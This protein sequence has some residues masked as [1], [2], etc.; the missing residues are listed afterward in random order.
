MK[1]L[2][3]FFNILASLFIVLA[4]TG[5]VGFEAQ[6][7]SCLE[8]F[9]QMLNSAGSLPQPEE[10][11]DG[12][13]ETLEL[14]FPEGRFS[15]ITDTET[16][17]DCYALVNGVL[18]SSSYNIEW[19][20]NGEL[21]SNKGSMYTFAPSAREKNITVEAVLTYVEKTDELDENGEYIEETTVL[22]DSEKFVYYEPFD[23]PTATCVESAEAKTYT[24]AGLS[25]NDLIEWYVNGERQSEGE[26]FVFCPT[27]A[28]RY[29]VSATVNGFVAEV[30]NPD[31]IKQ[32]PQVITDVNVD[33]DTYYPQV[34]ISFNGDSNAK[35]I[36]RKEYGGGYKDYSANTNSLLV[37]YDDFFSDSS[38]SAYTVRIKTVDDQVYVDSDY[39]SGFV[40]QKPSYKAEQYLDKTYGIENAYISDEDDFYEQFDYMMLS[41]EQPVNEE[42]S[43]SQSF[44]FG[45][46]IEGSI[47]GIVNRAFDACGYT[48]S[49]RLSASGT[50]PYTVTIKFKTGN[51]PSLPSKDNVPNTS[52]YAVNINGAPLAISKEGRSGE[53]P[54]DSRPAI[55]V[56]STD[57]IYRMAE[58]GYCPKAY[59]GTTEE[60]VINKAR[61]VLSV[62]TH[63]GMSDYEIALAVY[64]WVMYKNNYNNEVLSLSTDSAVKHPAFY[65]EGIMYSDNY[66]YAVCDG[67]SK[68]YSL[69]CNMAG[70][71]CI[72]VVGEAGQDGQFGGHAWNKVKVDGNW[73]T[74]DATWG[75]LSMGISYKAGGIFN[76][77]TYTDYYELGMHN[78]FLVTDEFV[79][80]NHKEDSDHYPQ[81]APIPY[82]HYAKQSM[83]YNGKT[84][85]MYVNE[86]GSQLQAKLDTIADAII[87]DVRS[88]GRIQSVNVGDVTKQSYYFFYE[89]GYS[90][91][92]KSNLVSYMSA[93]SS[94]VKKLRQQS[95]GFSLFEVDGT[96]G[97]IVSYHYGSRLPSSSL[98]IA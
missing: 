71:E 10:K 91:L 48:G 58:M 25:D 62:I 51:I 20:F 59:S 56:T 21:S 41:R 75:D 23:V 42:T 87:N 96:V 32:G 79:K 27:V 40:V 52:K 47:D 86:T 94:F 2:C 95:Y 77:T 7:T 89:I 30:E 29:T 1:K 61:S 92:A 74:V 54:I 76:Q 63:E 38:I 80:D 81:T 85:D 83:T 14:V 72:R 3:K 17:R 11:D 78:Y 69:L 16:F 5:C 24:I 53:L 67:I 60:A 46:S 13:P 70:V 55:T 44:Y 49:Y 93:T 36:V 97:I 82:N 35:Y 4:L 98:Y 64:D 6:L 39:S 88:K 45:F 73:Y 65:L 12:K 50:N 8:Q 90:P 18:A 22:S 37:S 34:L 43:I 15:S 84:V 66:G 19:S 31:M 68:T 33:F 28:G 9:A 26:T 57:Q